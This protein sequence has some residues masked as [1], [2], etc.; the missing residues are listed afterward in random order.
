MI[1]E[2]STKRRSTII[3]ECVIV[4]FAIAT[5]VIAQLTLSAAMPAASSADGDNKMAQAVTL[6]ALRFAGFFEFNSINPIQG[7][8]SQQLPINVWLNP[9]YWPFAFAHLDFAVSISATI[10]LAVFAVAGYIMARCFDVPPVPSPIGTQLCI[11]LFHGRYGH[12]VRLRSFHSS[13]PLERY[14]GH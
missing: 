12:R 7:V 6:A 13:L 2:A 1:G 10:A 5:L 9:T 8:G 4:A 3:F 11:G 14:C